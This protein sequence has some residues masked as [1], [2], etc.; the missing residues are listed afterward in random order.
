MGEETPAI[1]I[2]NFTQ[3]RAALAAAQAVNKPVSLWSAPG[4]GCYAG[5]GW[6]RGLLDLLGQT[7]PD[8]GYYTSV[9][10][11][12]DAPGFVMAAIRAQVPGIYFEG[13]PDITQKLSEMATA[14]GL[15]LVTVRPQALDLA[16]VK[17]PYDTCLHY[18]K[19]DQ[20]HG[21]A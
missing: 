12:S 8:Q 16:A 7:S 1:I 6:W 20:Q 3:A 19:G 17:I 5:A 13:M 14:Q 21:F 2:H 10:D 18:L 4:A 11:C 9:L 15:G